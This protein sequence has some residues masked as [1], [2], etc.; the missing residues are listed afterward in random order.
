MTDSAQYIFSG[1]CIAREIRY[2]EKLQ[3]EIYSFTFRVNHTL[4][5]PHQDE[6]IVQTSKTLVEIGQVPT[7]HFGDDVILFL[8]PESPLGFTSP[9]GLGQG[10]FS[11]IF[12]PGEGKKVVNENNN[13]DLFKGMDLSACMDLRMQSGSQSQV[14]DLISHTS[15]PIP[16][17]LFCSLIEAW[18]TR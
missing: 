14:T 11:I 8:Y 13:Q 2:D 9:V 4:K 3:R 1:V 12:E 17:D 7:Y 16:Y 15:G 5:G 6:R 18:L 10:K